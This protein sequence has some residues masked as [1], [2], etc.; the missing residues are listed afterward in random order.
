V[1]Q[2]PD[3]DLLLKLLE[4]QNEEFRKLNLRTARER[5]LRNLQQF[6]Q[7]M[8]SAPDAS[9]QQ[10]D[11]KAPDPAK[12]GYFYDVYG[13]SIFATPQQEQMFVRP[14][15]RGGTVEDLLRILRSK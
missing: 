13:P 6:Q 12:I 1:A 3:N 7:M 8:A 10:V 14:F 15:A 9:G 5:D 2:P 11:V 4:Q